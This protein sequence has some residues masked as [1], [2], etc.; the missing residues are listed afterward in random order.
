MSGSEQV[1]DHVEASLRN[2]PTATMGSVGDLATSRSG[3]LNVVLSIV[4][5]F[6]GL[7]VV[8]AVLG[9]VLGATIG[10]GCTWAILKTLA[11]SRSP[12]LAARD[13]GC[14]SHRVVRLLLHRAVAAFAG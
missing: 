6:L 1:L 7:A 8:I 3:A 12:S 5:G 13:L 10:L 9:P 11:G 14:R 2:H 4:V